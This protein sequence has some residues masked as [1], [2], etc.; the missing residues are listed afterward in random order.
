LSNASKQPC[1]SAVDEISMFKRKIEQSERSIVKLQAHTEKFT[2]PRDITPDEEF[3]TELHSIKREAERKF[4][5]ALTKFH[6][7]RVEHNSDKLGRAKSD[8]CRSKRDTD[9]A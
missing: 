2:Y 4:I 6:Y 8:T 9:R 5:G 7:R 3:K 1:Q